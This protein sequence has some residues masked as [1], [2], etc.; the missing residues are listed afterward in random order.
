M[1]HGAMLGLARD[2]QA[3]ATDPKCDNA[4]FVV[5]TDTYLS[6]NLLKYKY[7]PILK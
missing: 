3:R 1:R 5:F 2:A 4:Y 7:F 6:T